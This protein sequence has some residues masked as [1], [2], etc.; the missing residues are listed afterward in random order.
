MNEPEVFRKWVK[1]YGVPKE[2]K[3]GSTEHW[4]RKVK[5]A[6]S[7]E[8]FRAESNPMPKLVG[9]EESDEEGGSYGDLG[10]PIITVQHT[11]VGPRGGKKVE[12]VT[13]E[14]NA[15]HSRMVKGAESF[16][17]TAKM[18]FGFATGMAL[19][20]LTLLGVAMAFGSIKA[21]K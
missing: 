17:E 1:E 9:W 14:A 18:G 16:N 10:R 2:F 13:Y 21:K 3:V 5:M 7:A 6:H 20:Q 15:K 4:L 19:F 11:I 8:S 12:E